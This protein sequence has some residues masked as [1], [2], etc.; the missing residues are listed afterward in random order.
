MTQFAGLILAE[1][2][3]IPCDLKLTLFAGGGDQDK[4]FAP[5]LTVQPIPLLAGVRSASQQVDVTKRTNPDHD[6]SSGHN[7]KKP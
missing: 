6:C 3:D 4:E 7:P 1:N 5:H 2:I